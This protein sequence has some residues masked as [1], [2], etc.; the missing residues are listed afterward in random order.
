MHAAPRESD[1]FDAVASLFTSIGYFERDEDLTKTITGVVSALRANGLFV[2][3][4]LNPTQ[5]VSG[6][7]EHEVKESG[8]YTF[9]IHRRVSNGW[10]E[11]SIQYEDESGIQHHVERV[12]ALAPADWR[13]LLHAAGLVVEA[14]F[15][16]YALNPWQEHAPRSI[17][18]AR[19]IP[20]G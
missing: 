6:L 1:F 5:V 16:D 9:T 13:K 11:K 12:R 3:D 18:V 10:I 20:C 17:L 15:G 2:L 19:K 8:G 14:H 7:V 4:F